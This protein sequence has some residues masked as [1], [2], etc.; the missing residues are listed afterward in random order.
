MTSEE[1][2]QI[3]TKKADELMMELEFDDPSIA[4][5]ACIEAAC[6]IALKN[7]REILVG[8]KLIECGNLLKMRN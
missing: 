5:S 6:N 8:D 1:Y 2:A 3:I 4:V 7:N